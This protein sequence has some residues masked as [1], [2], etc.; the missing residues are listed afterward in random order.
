MRATVETLTLASCSTSSGWTGQLLLEE[1]VR[2]SYALKGAKDNPEMEYFN[3]RFKDEGRSLFLDAQSLGEL[4]A[5]V[6]RCVR[7]YNTARRHS[8]LGY[9][10]PST[11]LERVRSD[12]KE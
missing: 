5:A 9:Q 2:L 6:E 1:R 11:Y 10:A 3:G 8:S 7:Y 12:V 4:Q